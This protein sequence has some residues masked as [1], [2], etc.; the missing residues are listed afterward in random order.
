MT[1]E[2]A[3]CGL[4]KDIDIP[5]T[6]AKDMS[7]E[8][9]DNIVGIVYR[10]LMEIESRLLPCGLHVVG[11]PPSAEEAIATL[12]NIAG[13]DRPEEEIKSLQRIIA[14]SID[15]DIEEIYRI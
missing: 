2:G 13:L 10:K 5:E 9:R 1:V 12:V 3:E 14:E 8:E 7:S 4:D 6:D 11:K 15:R